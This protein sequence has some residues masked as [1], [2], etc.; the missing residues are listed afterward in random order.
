MP[1]RIPAAAA[2][3]LSLVALATLSP[4]A[5][6]GPL[7][8]QDGRCALWA[9]ADTEPRPGDRAAWDGG[10]RDGLGEGFGIHD[11]TRAD[12][13]RLRYVGPVRAGRWHGLGRLQHVA[14]DGGLLQVVEG[15]FEDGAEQGVFQELVFDHPQNVRLEALSP[16]GQAL[17]RGAV[18]V[19]QFYTDGAAVL[20]C[21]PGADCVR[22]A[23]AEGYLPHPGV[24]AGDAD[25]PLPRGGW[26][27]E[28][29][30]GGNAQRSGVCLA[31]AGAAPDR[32]PPEG[33]P[34]F[35]SFSAWEGWLRDGH[36]C[37]DLSVARQG[38]A[39]RWTSQCRRPDGAGQ[40]RITLQR[41]MAGN[42]VY[43]RTDE[44]T[45]RSGRE[46]ARRSQELRAV[47]VGACSADMVRAGRLGL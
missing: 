31:P 5:S 34:L 25:R 11:L 20:M 44:V 40:V 46:V 3:A 9:G 47:F 29:R 19:Q 2:A 28:R 42:E 33:S 23:V 32:E 22:E 43:S 37:D 17:G 35:P 14:P 24:L 4:P 13:S 16:P 36:R 7:P 27:L 39:L 38:D 15:E 18:R 8:T 30:E 10:C 12:G 45:V 1:C 41:R 6:A 26:R 21:A